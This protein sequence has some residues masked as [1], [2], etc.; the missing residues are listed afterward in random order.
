[1]KEDDLKYLKTSQGRCVAIVTRHGE[2]LIANVHWVSE[3]EQD[4]I[5]ELISTNKQGFQEGCLYAL[6]LEDIIS[7]RPA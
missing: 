7:V 5:Y 2:T 3:E 1:M 6:P 4:L